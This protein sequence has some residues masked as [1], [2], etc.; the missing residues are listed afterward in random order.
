MASSSFVESD[1]SLKNEK[2]PFR[3]KDVTFREAAFRVHT[4]SDISVLRGLQLCG[5]GAASVSYFLS[6]ILSAARALK[7]GAGLKEEHRQ[8]Q[9]EDCLKNP[10][11][12]LGAHAFWSYVELSE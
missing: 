5:A 12:A 11:G 10:P 1:C 9:W 6:F 8:R 2:I 7:G 3:V 4:G